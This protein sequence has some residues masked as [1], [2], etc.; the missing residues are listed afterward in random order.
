LSEAW[1]AGL[2]EPS[3]FYFNGSIQQYLYMMEDDDILVPGRGYWFYAYGLSELWV[4]NVSVSD[5]D[6][7]I[8]QIVSGWNN[9][10]VPIDEHI[11]LGDLVIEYDTVEYV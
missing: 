7:S 6:N 5:W 3:V 10:G 2:V 8:A 4:N 11:L 9:I 1:A